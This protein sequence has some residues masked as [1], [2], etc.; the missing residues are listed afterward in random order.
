MASGPHPRMTLDEHPGGVVIAHG[1][2]RAATSSRTSGRRWRAWRM[3]VR[4]TGSHGRRR[5]VRLTSSLPVYRPTSTSRASGPALSYDR[6]RVVAPRRVRPSPDGDPTAPDPA[7]GPSPRSVVRG[8]RYAGASPT[9]PSGQSTV[10][11]HLGGRP[12]DALAR[13]RNGAPDLPARLATPPM[14]STGGPRGPW[15][16]G[17]R[18]GRFART[19]GPRSTPTSRLTASLARMSSGSSEASSGGCVSSR[20]VR[21]PGS[22]RT[23]GR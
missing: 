12:A 16:R 18:T 13:H 1:G 20:S 15:P 23:S 6:G 4:D 10:R 5:S 19:P 22:C 14:T 21:D 8:L 9:G 17:V 11:R 2:R 3:S 7:R